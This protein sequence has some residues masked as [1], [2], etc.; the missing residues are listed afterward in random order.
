MNN[1]VVI[2]GLGI[3]SCLGNNLDEDLKISPDIIVLRK[4]KTCVSPA[5]FEKFLLKANYERFVFPIADYFINNIS[6]TAYHL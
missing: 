1:R 2:T 4:R 3:W 6:E 5:V